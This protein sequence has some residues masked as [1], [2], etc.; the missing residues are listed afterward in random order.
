MNI[1]IINSDSP[2]RRYMTME[3]RLLDQILRSIIWL[4]SNPTATDFSF[5]DYLMKFSATYRC[6]LIPDHG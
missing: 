5:W 1:Q 3:H 2:V 4:R 6:F